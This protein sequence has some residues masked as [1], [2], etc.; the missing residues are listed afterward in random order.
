MLPGAATSLE[1]RVVA[2]GAFEAVAGVMFDEM[3]ESY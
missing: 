2:P 3:P 1:T